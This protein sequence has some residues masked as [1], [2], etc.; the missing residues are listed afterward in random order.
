MK[1]YSKRA[2]EKISEVMQKFKKGEL[3]SSSGEKVTNRDQALAI[4]ISQADNEGLKVPKQK[5]EYRKSK[6]KKR[7]T[8]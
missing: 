8:S 7:I 3:K 5:R 2:Q 6:S 4:G 1:R